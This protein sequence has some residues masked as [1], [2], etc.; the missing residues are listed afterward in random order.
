M[1]TKNEVLSHRLRHVYWL[2][3]GSGAGKSTVARRL[4]TTYG[5]QLYSTDDAMADHGRR[6]EPEACPFLTAFKEMDMD[7]RWLNRSPE[8]MLETFHWYRGEAF[9]LI[10]EDLLALPA[11]QGVLVEG[12]RLLPRLVKPLLKSNGQAAWLI[13]TPEFRLAAFTTRGT[14]MDIAGKTSAPSRALENLLR[15]DDMFTS[16]L[17]REVKDERLPIINVGSV[18]C[19]DDLTSRVAELFGL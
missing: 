8:L 17:E 10:V 3:G 9:G 12:F 11:D 19:V 18:M 1:T 6:C 15:R 14:L 13:P 16:R 2:G 5:L 4:A 7:E